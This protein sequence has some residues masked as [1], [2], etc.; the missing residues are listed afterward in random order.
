MFSK[1]IIFYIFFCATIIIIIELFSFF[2]LRFLFKNQ[3][4]QKQIEFYSKAYQT[5]NQKEILNRHKLN[6]EQ[7]RRYTFSS[8]TEYDERT[9]NGKFVKVSKDNFRDPN[10]NKKLEYGV[11]T[12][13]F[14]GGSTT[15]GY[16]VYDEETIPRQFEIFS[17]DKY[18]VT[19]LSNSKKNCGVAKSNIVAKKKGQC[20]GEIKVIYSNGKTK[21][22]KF[23]LQVKT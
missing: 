21:T 15:F 1:K 5:N 22:Q 11:D 8:F 2:S 7:Y 6:T 20:K 14:F 16:G 13:Y 18:K 3:I 9:Y 19:L 23:Q 4:T 10:F 12:V 17:K